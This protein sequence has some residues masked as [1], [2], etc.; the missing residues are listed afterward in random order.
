MEDLIVI[1]N[2]IKQYYK[3]QKDIRTQTDNM[4]I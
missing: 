1:K 2:E 4:D 3:M